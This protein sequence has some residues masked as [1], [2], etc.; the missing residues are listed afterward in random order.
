M[1]HSITSLDFPTNSMNIKLLHRYLK[2]TDTETLGRKFG[3]DRSMFLFFSL[4]DLCISE[5][6]NILQRVWVRVTYK[7][8][9]WIG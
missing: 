2:A 1:P 5:Y 3:D 6:D 7:T 9:F 4:T 8:G